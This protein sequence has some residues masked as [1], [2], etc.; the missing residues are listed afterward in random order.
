MAPLT[1]D[2][3]EG[4]GGEWKFSKVH[5]SLLG[6]SYVDVLT[7]CRKAVGHSLPC[8]RLSNFYQYAP[9]STDLKVFI[10]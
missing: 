7:I 9:V 10:V 8:E 2:G 6:W 4:D 3:N 1:F 5:G